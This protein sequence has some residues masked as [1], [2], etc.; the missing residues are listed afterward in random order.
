MDDLTKPT[1]NF[2][3]CDG[4]LMN[5]GLW[6]SRRWRRKKM[7]SLQMAT[8]MHDWLVVW[9]MNF[10]TFHLQ[11]MSSSQ[12]IFI[13]FQ[14]VQ[15]TN[16]IWFIRFID[17]DCRSTT[18]QTMMEKRLTQIVRGGRLQLDPLAVHGGTKVLKGT[19]IGYEGLYWDYNGIIMGFNG[20]IIHFMKSYPLAI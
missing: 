5:P 3:H 4:C 17:V 12:V 8:V 7:S 11:R 9:N 18:N 6:Y 13:F 14:R 1:C 10:M 20:I 15:T 16:Q 19:G 2:L